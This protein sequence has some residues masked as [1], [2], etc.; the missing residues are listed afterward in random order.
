MC[1][2]EL[3]AALPHLEVLW[4]SRCGLQDLDGVTVLGSL[5]ELY[6][7]FNDVADLSPLK[8]LDGLAVLDIEGNALSGPSD[9]AELRKCHQLRELTLI[10]NPVCRDS[11]FSR[12]MVLEMLPQISILDDAYREEP[13]A[14]APVVRDPEFYL[15]LYIESDVEL[16]LDLFLESSGS[17]VNRTEPTEMVPEVSWAS[18]A[19]SQGLLSGPLPPGVA[20]VYV[21]EPGEEELVVEWLKRMRPKLAAPQAHASTTRTISE[22]AGFDLRLADRRQAPR[23]AQSGGF[24][25]DEGSGNYAS[26]L[27][28]GDSL[29]GNPL[30]ALRHRRSQASSS[31]VAR[32][33]DLSIR[34]LLRRHRVAGL[35]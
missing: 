13:E 34:E 7:P 30:S 16:Y 22:P 28:R 29:A 21:G 14:L 17:S 4:M 9:V 15:D 33:V 19:M 23:G 12:D 6:L 32:P 10:G 18:E 20:D 3:G 5:Q 1:M 25:A 2:R 8:W 27:T 11:G 35:T 26:D 24:A 31:S